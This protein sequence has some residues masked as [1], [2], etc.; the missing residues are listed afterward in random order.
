MKS[1]L[2]IL[3]V[4]V[5]LAHAEEFPSAFDEREEA[6]KTWRLLERDI[7][8]WDKVRTHAYNPPSSPKYQPAAE[9]CFNV[10]ALIHPGDRDPLDVLL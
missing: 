6:Q 3:S 2:A 10:E 4:I 5:S 8:H 9:Q 7:S 1:F